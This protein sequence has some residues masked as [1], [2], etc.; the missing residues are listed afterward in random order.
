M[1]TRVI[2]LRSGKP[3]DILVD[4]SSPFGNPFSHLADTLAEF[5]TPTKYE[6]VRRF[7]QWVRLNPD[8]I[9][10]I[11]TELKDKTL[12]CHCGQ[13]NINRGMCHATILARIADE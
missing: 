12:A 1:S 11:K 6:A 2:C 8:L 10:R 9:R 3:Y 4:R 13:N 5:K 7:S